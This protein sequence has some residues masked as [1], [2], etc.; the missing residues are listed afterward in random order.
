MS[1]PRPAWMLLALLW[2]GLAGA[3]VAPMPTP[4]DRASAE[5]VAR[6]PD[7]SPED[8][9]AK[10]LRADELGEAALFVL[11]GPNPILVDQVVDPRTKMVIG[12]LRALPATEMA[13]LRSGNT[14]VRHRAGWTEAELQR[15][16]ELATAL[17]LKK[18]SKVQ[19][20]RIGVITGSNMRL[21]LIGKKGSASLEFAIAP[22]PVRE[23]RARERL[24]K[25]FSARPAEVTRGPG[26]RL[27]LED[28]SF[29]DPASLGGVWAMPTCVE[30]GGAIPTAQVALD[31]DVALDGRS[32]VR[33]HSDADTRHWPQVSQRVTIA[34]GTRL[35]LRG[36]VKADY[37][38]RE[39]DQERLF[40]LALQFLDIAGNPVGKPVEAPLQLGDMD[41]RQFVVAAEAPFEADLVEVVL[42]CTVSGTAWFD[43]L[44]LEIG[45]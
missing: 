26:T 33:F 34:P 45:Y 15:L 22:T 5:L 21:E 29:E 10:L 23:E 6:M 32:S 1:V 11:A 42:A 35:V 2:P 7:A 25:H 9:V 31:A 14:V 30:R 17:A 20:V 40:R 43:G 8:R 39:R 18:P 4:Q 37:L 24:T 36:H 44:S 19:S 13:D 16:V 12:Y 41:W 28:A 38:R 27:P 3:V